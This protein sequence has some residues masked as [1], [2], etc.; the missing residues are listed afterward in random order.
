MENNQV[1]STIKTDM[2]V[3]I[4]DLVAA[5]V[6]RWETS[7]FELKDQL[8]Q[9]IAQLNKDIELVTGQVVQAGNQMF[10]PMSKLVI[11]EG[12][13]MSFKH[14]K[15]NVTW[16]TGDTVGKIS[17]RF[18]VT[19]QTP[20]NDYTNNASGKVE[21]DIPAEYLTNYQ[22]LINK[23]DDLTQQLTKVLVEIKS[24]SRKERQLRGKLLEQKL[25]GQGFDEL[26]NQ[27]EFANLLTVNI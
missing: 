20:G 23:R 17:V 16:P 12:L 15:C 13:P 2:T 6:S 3:T 10:E 11:P 7:L 9:Q 21:F 24:V 25:Q 22:D 19:C 5:M 4:T 18:I 14:D 1:L 27:P 8:N 26:V